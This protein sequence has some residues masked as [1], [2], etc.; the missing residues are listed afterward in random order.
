[1]PA[2][3]LRALLL[4]LIVLTWLALL[5]LGVWLL[6][7]FTKTI[8]LV[9]L[10]AILAFGFTPPQQLSRARIQAESQQQVAFACGQEDAASGD[11]R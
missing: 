4:P 5:V 1:M 7:H 3:W 11:H 6:S 10:A 8:L 2:S 9:T